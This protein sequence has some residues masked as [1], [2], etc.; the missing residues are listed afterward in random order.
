MIR[1]LKKNKFW[2]ILISALSVLLAAMDVFKGILLQIIVDTS[3][4]KEQHSFLLIFAVVIF[5]SIF[6]FL[7]YFLFQKAMYCGSTKALA[8]IKND[9][10]NVLLYGTNNQYK[11]MDLL[12]TMNK[13]VDIILEKYYFNIFSLLRTASSFLFSL[14]YLLSVNVWLTIIILISGSVSV[15]LPN[16]FIRKSGDLKNIYSNNNGIFLNSIKELLYGLTTIKLYGVEKEFYNAN[17]C[18]N[19][20][21]E[22]SR[23]KTLFFDSIIQIIGLC[24]G[25]L[26]LAGNVVLAGYLSFKGFFTIGTVLAV[27]Q[28]MNYILAPLVQGPVC[29]AQIKSVAPISKKII[30]Y[31]QSQGKAKGCDIHK[32]VQN[33]SVRDVTFKYPQKSENALSHINIEFDTPNKYIVIGSSGCGKSTL[34][35]LLSAL[36]EDYLG[37]ISINQKQSLKQTDGSRWR[38]KI[39]VV[40]QDVFLF[41]NTLKYN[42]C[43]NNTVTNEELDELVE[44][45]GLKTFVD[46]LPEGINSLVGENGSLISGGQKQRIA[47]ARA[48]AKKTNVLLV[49]EATSALDGNNA[50]HIENVLLSLYDKLVIIISH[51]FDKILLSRFDKVIVIEE[52]SIAACGSYEII[53]DNKI[54]NK[55]LANPLPDQSSADSTLENKIR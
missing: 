29:F 11:N 19:E 26:V 13:D 51:R 23:E 6:N 40:P 9:I 2:C 27:M 5:F 3:V 44:L 47:I 35:K 14:A 55:L 42:I 33:I 12:S 7:A 43:L 46:S 25:F 28:I 48:L 49:D 54:L 45:V 4:G 38:S 36:E 22:K 41:D 50:N 8:N 16:F 53:K 39:A 17:K 32:S 24:I 1:Y 10:L 20:R 30:Q 18:S 21:L 15:L 31:T 52:G 34:F 37:E